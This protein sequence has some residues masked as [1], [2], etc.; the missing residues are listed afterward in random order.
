[1]SNVEHKTK[2]EIIDM[3]EEALQRNVAKNP[4]VVHKPEYA[5]LQE[6]INRLKN[7]SG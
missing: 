7:G 6:T 3:L 1:M 2:Q 5:Q 4:N